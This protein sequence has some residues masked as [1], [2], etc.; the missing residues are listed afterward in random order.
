MALRV[1]GVIAALGGELAIL[2]R[3]TRLDRG[4]REKRNWVPAFAEM[5]KTANVRAAG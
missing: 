5:T 2:F 1:S 4:T 3:H